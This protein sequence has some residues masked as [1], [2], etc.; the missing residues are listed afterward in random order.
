MIK[1]SEFQQIKRN[2]EMLHISKDSKFFFSEKEAIEYQKT[3]NGSSK[4]DQWQMILDDATTEELAKRSEEI[5]QLI[6]T[7]KQEQIAEYGK[8]FMNEAQENLLRDVYKTS[9][10][11]W[12]VS[13]VS[14][15]SSQELISEGTEYGT[16][17]DEINGATPVVVKS[18]IIEEK[19]F[20]KEGIEI[21]MIVHAD[22]RPNMSK[23]M[24]VTYKDA[25]G[26]PVS[27]NCYP[28]VLEGKKYGTV[29]AQFE[30]VKATIRFDE[31]IAKAYL[32]KIKDFF[33]THKLVSVSGVSI[34]AGYSSRYLSLIIEGAKPITKNVSDAVLK[35][36]KKYG[37]PS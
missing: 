2:P 26:E 10:D 29:N 21:T 27:Y 34:E 24:R 1:R 11:V 6:E 4:I 17:D 25:N 30:Y 35:V 13:F 31:A 8:V 16:Y 33:E 32:R 23:M 22:D 37:M 19:T 14:L 3:I 18:N 12:S 15:K 9:V 5:E 7:R 28:D 20:E 36:L